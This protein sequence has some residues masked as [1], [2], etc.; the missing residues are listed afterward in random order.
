MFQLKKLTTLLFVALSFTFAFA[1]SQDAIYTYKNNPNDKVSQTILRVAKKYVGT[2]Y[3]AGTLEQPKETLICRTDAFDCFTFVEHCVALTRNAH[4]DKPSYENYQKLLAELR[5]H[6]GMIDGYGSRLHYFSGWIL[7]ASQKKIVVDVLKDTGKLLEKKI[8]FMSTH[9]GLY[10]MNIP[11]KEW[12]KVKA[13]ELQLSQSSFF[14]LPKDSI[15]V[16]QNL[17]QSGD[18]IAFTSTIDGLDVNH[19]GIAVWLDNSLRFVHASS[20]NKKV[21]LS[22]ETLSAY[23]NRIKKHAGI[24]VYRLL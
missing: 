9:K 17:I 7:Q 8:Q 14:Y 5:Y 15:E 16:N 18:I 13:Q 6:Q 12:N 11:V 10:P 4:S 24:F 19:E 21:E 20:E 23:T 1:Q 3:L 2:P 22:S